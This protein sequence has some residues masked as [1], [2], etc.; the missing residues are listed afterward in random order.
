VHH[1]STVSAALDAVCAA[2]IN[3][4]DA[5]ATEYGVTI[6]EVF[7]HF[8]H[9]EQRRYDTKSPPEAPAVPLP[10]LT[11][12]GLR[13]SSYIKTITCEDSKDREARVKYLKKQLT[14]QI[15]LSYPILHCLLTNNIR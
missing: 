8:R 9:A 10:S 14:A 15:C 13:Y 1:E 3:M 7:A 11:S 5:K 6:G 4:L 12:A 2:A